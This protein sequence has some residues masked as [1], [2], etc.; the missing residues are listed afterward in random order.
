LDLQKDRIELN[1]N[2][3][4][5]KTI[6]HNTFMLDTDWIP[7]NAFELSKNAYFIY[8]RFIL[9][10]ISGKNKPKEIRLWFE[11][12][13]SFLD[14]HWGNDRGIHSTID[15][16]FKDMLAKGLVKGYSWNKD[17][18]YR[19]Y[20]LSFESPQKRIE[21]QQNKDDKVMKLPT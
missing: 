11:D 20:R 17:Y 18:G 6:L 14:M 3:P 5:G 12:I 2:T 10:R 15:K 1:F 9:N 13:K 7:E 19:Q 16:A 4:L 21:K 8:K